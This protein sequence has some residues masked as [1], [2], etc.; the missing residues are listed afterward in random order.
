M[1]T[2]T[3]QIGNSDDKLSQK[4]WSAYVRDVGMCI[5]TLCPD[6]HFFGGSPNWLEWQNVAWVFNSTKEDA[7]ALYVELVDIRKKYN[8]ESIAWTQGNTAFI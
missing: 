4:E 5:R 8:Q 1:I 2:V 7:T 6:V 3:V